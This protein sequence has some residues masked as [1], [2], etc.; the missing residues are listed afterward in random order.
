MIYST[1]KEVKHGLMVL[2]IKDNIDKVLK[3]DLENISGLME[4]YTKVNGTKIQLVVMC[5]K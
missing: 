3:M 1:E 4:M 5:Y 2:N